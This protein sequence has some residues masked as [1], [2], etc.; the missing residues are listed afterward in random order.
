M[1]LVRLL[2]VSLT[3]LTLSAGFVADVSAGGP[4][5]VPRRTSSGLFENYYVEP[6]DAGGIG[7]KMYPSPRPVP[8]W[9]GGTYYTYQG[10][11]PHEHMYPHSRTYYRGRGP[12]GMIPVNKTHILYW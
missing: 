12:M 9:V 3:A 8:A 1:S 11:Y 7:S 5:P 10:L 4:L 2:R 6:A